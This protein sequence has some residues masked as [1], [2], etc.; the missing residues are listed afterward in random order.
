MPASRARNRPPD[1]NP[2]IKPSHRQ[3]APDIR[4]TTE[5]PERFTGFDPNPSFDD[6]DEQSRT[7]MATIA[8]YQARRDRRLAREARRLQPINADV[9]DSESD[10]EAAPRAQSGTIRI[11]GDHN[12]RG[13]TFADE[14][15]Q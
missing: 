14:N 11:R 15:P 10:T 2:S 9:G 13:S 8:Q 7:N 3:L 1:E 5:R 4:V 6:V 12:P